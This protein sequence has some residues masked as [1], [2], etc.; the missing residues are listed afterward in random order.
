M[1]ARHTVKLNVN[2][3]CLRMQAR[4]DGWPKWH[5]ELMAAAVRAASIRRQLRPPA[6][7]ATGVFM[8][9]R[10]MAAEPEVMRRQQARKNSRATDRGWSHSSS[11][12]VL[13]RQR[14]LL[15]G[16]HS[17]GGQFWHVVVSEANSRK[18]DEMC[19]SPVFLKNIECSVFKVFCWLQNFVSC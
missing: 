11:R 9:S 4:G 10:R 13:F 7:L 3:G 14:S 17:S 18:E 16:A 6:D 12:G 2:R 15:L 8:L 5:K 19:Y 1:Q